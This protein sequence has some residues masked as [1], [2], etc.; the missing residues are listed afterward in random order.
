MQTEFAHVGAMSYMNC[1]C[2]IMH[3][4]HLAQCRPYEK[5]LQLCNLQRS[6]GQG[7]VRLVGELRKV[8]P[9][10]NPQHANHACHGC[11]RQL[12]FS[13]LC[14]KPGLAIAAGWLQS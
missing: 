8:K 5:V 11:D 12:A 10:V 2:Q 4:G 6:C 14:H 7:W 13:Q 9:A 3:R 1:T